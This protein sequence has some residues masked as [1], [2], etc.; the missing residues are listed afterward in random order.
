MTAGNLIERQL[1]WV[2]VYCGSRDGSRPAYRQAAVDL[3]HALALRG[4]GLVYGGAQAGLMGAV[5][6][7]VL[8]GG[9]QVI[10]VLP[11]GLARAG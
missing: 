3:G 11:R 9:Q 5:A 2:G 8:G 10:G 7:G 1:K 4:L 6:D